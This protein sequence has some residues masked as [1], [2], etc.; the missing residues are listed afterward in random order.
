[1]SIMDAFE[2]ECRFRSERWRH[3]SFADKR[4]KV[5][6]WV[7]NLRKELNSIERW[8]VASA[9]GGVGI[10]YFSHESVHVG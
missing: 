8:T 10:E 2:V 1:M 4:V 5:K 6:D 3:H 9:Y 7:E